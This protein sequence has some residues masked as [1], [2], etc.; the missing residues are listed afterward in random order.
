M[1]AALD[2]E[3]QETIDALADQLAPA[4]SGAL[5]ASLQK[6]LTEIDGTLRSRRGE[7]DAATENLAEILDG[8]GREMKSKATAALTDG[9]RELELRS[10]QL[11]G[12]LGEKLNQA[13]ER[14]R[15]EIQL[16]AQT[17]QQAIVNAADPT[18]QSLRELFAE[19]RE[20]RSEAMRQW[21]E[22]AADRNTLQQKTAGILQQSL[23]L[24]QRNLK[25]ILA[26][27][28]GNGLLVLAVLIAIL[29]TGH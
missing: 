18:R 26:A 24:Q 3:A 19:L 5:Q 25:W 16:S 7:I 17:T 20:F 9:I 23:Q 28:L 13:G 1:N 10:A 11:E 6:L 29:A 14:L 15:L 2:K 22:S 21:Q 27:Q 8:L 12:R 4:I